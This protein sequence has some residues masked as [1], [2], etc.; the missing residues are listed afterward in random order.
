MAGVQYPNVVYFKRDLR[1]V[2][3]RMVPGDSGYADRD[4]FLL[5]FFQVQTKD[6]G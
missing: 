1:N 5:C 4:P 2:W 6:G 3:D